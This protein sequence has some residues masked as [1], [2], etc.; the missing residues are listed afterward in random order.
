M[1]GS[2][3]LDQEPSGGSGPLP[4]RKI[5]CGADALEATNGPSKATNQRI[6]GCGAR[7]KLAGLS[8]MRE[9]AWVHAFII[10]SMVLIAS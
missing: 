2:A 10:K 8:T 7:A 4:K 6:S 5:A 9:K 1:S 3:G